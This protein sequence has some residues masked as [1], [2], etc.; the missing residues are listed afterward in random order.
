[1][2]GLVGGGSLTGKLVRSMNVC[3]GREGIYVTPKIFSI[4]DTSGRELGSQPQH[5]CINIH[6]S[7]VK[8]R[9]AGLGGRLP[10][11]TARTVAAC[12]RSLKGS[13]PVNSCDVRGNGEIKP[14]QIGPFV[15][16]LDDD[17]RK[18]EGSASL[19][20]NSSSFKISD[21]VHRVV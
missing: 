15:T 8:V 21:A 1:M 17:H 20:C 4:S 19:P 10:S 7:L 12:G 5:C 11:I 13:V 2:E 6:Q 3:R 9:I 14:G 18:G 16:Y